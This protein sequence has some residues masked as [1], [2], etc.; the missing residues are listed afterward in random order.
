MRARH[1]VVP[2]RTLEERW[3]PL[4]SAP[5]SGT[6]CAASNSKQRASHYLPPLCQSF[7]MAIA[8]VAKLAPVTGGGP[9]RREH[10][11]CAS[12]PWSRSLSA[13]RLR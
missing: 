5:H 8:N 2:P 12:K 10:G 13:M 1:L 11:S 6:V 9:L 4:L 7:V 3:Y